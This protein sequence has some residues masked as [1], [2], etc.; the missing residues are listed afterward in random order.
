MNLRFLWFWPES[1]F[2]VWVIFLDFLCLF[3]LFLLLYCIVP[4]ED[5]VYFLFVSFFESR[6]TTNLFFILGWCYQPEQVQAGNHLLFYTLLASLPLLVGILFVYN[7]LV[8]LCLFLLC[9]NNSLV[10][11]VLLT[12]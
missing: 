4:L 5:L 10:G 1:L 12:K 6:L 8:S 9:G 2:F 7:S 11:V 3:L